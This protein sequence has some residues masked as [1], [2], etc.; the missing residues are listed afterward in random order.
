MNSSLTGDASTLI[1]APDLLVNV[2]LLIMTVN[3][4]SWSFALLD[5]RT[6]TDVFPVKVV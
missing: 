2:R 5:A 4:D 1:V 3:D 6:V